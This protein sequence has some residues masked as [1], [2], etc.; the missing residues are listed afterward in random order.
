MNVYPNRE[1]MGFAAARAGIEIMQRL[2]AEKGSVNLMFAAAPSQNEVLFCLQAAKDVEYSRITALHMDE[3]LDLPP[4]APQGFGTFLRERLFSRVPCQKVWYIADGSNFSDGENMAARY[5]QILADNPIDLCFMGIGENGHVAF[6]DPGVADFADAHLVKTVKL[7]EICR[8]QQVNDGCFP[9]L[10]QVPTHA[11]TATIPA[12]MSAK[13]I[14][15]T[16]PSRTKA[17]AV[18]A[19]L[20]D[21]ISTLCPATILRQHG[22]ARLY[23]D[24]DAAALL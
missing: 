17:R 14:L 24:A 13:Y 12:L 8:Q 11:V 9:S 15:C 19:T 23:L 6:N 4:N 16:V 22:N 7:D 18:R 10:S 3:Y 2:L 20:Q 21:E 5:E 1:A